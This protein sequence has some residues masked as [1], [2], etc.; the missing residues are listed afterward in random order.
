MEFIADSMLGRLAKWLRVMGYDVHYQIH[1]KHLQI[2][3]LVQEGRLLLSRKRQVVDLYPGA[4]FIASDHVR[5]Q[6]L[7][8]KRGRRLKSDPSK[9]F[10]RCLVCNAPLVKADPSTA[11]EDIPEYVFY[12]NPEG[13]RQCPSCTRY[14]WPGTHR[15]RMVRQLSEWGW[16]LP[17]K[18]RA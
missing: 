6:L 18:E 14:F 13:I 5:D 8:L 4:V 16:T 10:T 17:Q 3:T 12:K 9:W 2:E 15:Q 1:Y 11:R 7:E